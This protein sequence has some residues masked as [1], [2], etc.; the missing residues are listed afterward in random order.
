MRVLI[1]GGAGFVG[2]YLARA[3]REQ[4]SAEVVAFDNLRRRGSELNLPAFRRLGIEFVHG[5]VRVASDLEDLSGDFDL[6]VDA[7][8]E[9]SVSAGLSGSPQY[10]LET[11]L[12]GTLNSLEL[13]RKRGSSFL[14]LSTSRVYSIPALK[15]IRLTERDGRFALA[16][17]QDVAGVSESGI[18]ECFPVDEPRSFYGAGKLSSE[19]VTQEYVAAYGLKAIINRCGVIAGPGQFGKSDQGVFTMWVLHHFFRRPLRYTGFGGQGKQVRDLLHPADLFALIQKQLAA[20]ADHSGQVFNVGGGPTIS[21]SLRELTELCRERLGEVPISSDP[22]TSWVDV[23]L[24]IS[25][26]A[27]AHSV[28]GWEPTRSLSEIVADIIVWIRHN[29]TALRGLLLSEPAGE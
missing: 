6:L 1:T 16:A 20:A 22:D 7:A 14:L 10:L 29:E 27:K 19:M 11:N 15:R 3:F 5:D 21:T 17:E 2:A 8:A 26:C 25:D 24:Y 9:P 23:P 13:A 18:A 4:V 12:G 28:F